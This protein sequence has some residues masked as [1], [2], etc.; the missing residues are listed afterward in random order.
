MYGAVGG[1]RTHNREFLRLPRLPIAPPPHD[2]DSRTDQEDSND[3]GPHTRE[4]E[5]S[6]LQSKGIDDLVEQR[7]DTEYNSE[8]KPRVVFHVSPA[9]VVSQVD[10]DSFTVSSSGS[11]FE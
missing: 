7:P 11:H 3:S 2:L 8:F 5:V 4:L 1:N 10:P 6:E 9:V